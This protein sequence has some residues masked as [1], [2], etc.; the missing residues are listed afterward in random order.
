MNE[1]TRV[2]HELKRAAEFT[3][4]CRRSGTHV[5]HVG[6]ERSETLDVRVPRRGFDDS[7]ASFI[8]VL[9]QKKQHKEK[10]LNVIF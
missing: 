6:S 2:G 3:V 7:V 8:L 9:R 5:K 1:L 10:Q 4:T